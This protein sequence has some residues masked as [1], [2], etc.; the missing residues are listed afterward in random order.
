MKKTRALLLFVILLIALSV[1]FACGGCKH[2]FK[3]GVCVECG[4]TDPDYKPPCTHYFKDG[5]CTM[6]GAPSPTLEPECVLHSYVGGA[7]QH[8]GEPCLHPSYS[9][10]SCTSCGTLCP[11]SFEQGICSVCGVADPSYPPADGGASLYSPVISRFKEIILYK[12]L[13]EILPP[14]RGRMS[15][16]ATIRFSPSHPTTTPRSSSDTLFVISTMTASSSFSC[17]TAIPRSDTGRIC[18]LHRRKFLACSAA[19]ECRALI[20]KKIVKIIN[21]SVVS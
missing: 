7:C 13:N 5:I 4:K 21:R 11:H 8:C 12:H 20:R 16:P 6:C 9:D 3:E 2:Y 19:A 17:S 15:L 18:R 1:L 10:G 14:P